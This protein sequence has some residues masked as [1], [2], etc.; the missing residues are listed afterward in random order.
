MSLRRGLALVV[1]LG[2]ATHD[3]EVKRIVQLRCDDLSQKLATMSE[4]HRKRLALKDLSPTQS[5]AADQNL[6][7]LGPEGRAVASRWLDNE[8][9]FCMQVRA[10]GDKAQADRINGEFG[11]LLQTYRESTAMEQIASSLEAMHALAGEMTKLP[12]TD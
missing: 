6:E 2:C 1:L 9:G 11:H 12:L 8:F 7:I 3:S 4:A 10:K 5:A